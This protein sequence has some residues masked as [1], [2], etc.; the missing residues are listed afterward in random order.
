MNL[1]KSTRIIAKAIRIIT[2]APVIAAILVLVLFGYKEYTPVHAAFALLFLSGL[3]LVSYPISMLFKNCRRRE[4]QRSL[5]I[6]FSV[7]GYIGGMIFCLCTD[8]GKIESVVYL[9][10]LLSGVIT[11]LFSFLF[12]I[13][14]SGHACGVSGPITVMSIFCSPLF[15]L[16]Y[17]LLIPV[18][19]SSLLLKRHT[20]FQ[21]ILGTATPIVCLAISV[22]VFGV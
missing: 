6:A 7:A 21:L 14:A 18:Y 17:A 11:A 5:A 3:P 15:A 9:T 10:Y 12:H 8:S 13:K 19:R 16:G 4:N 22:L 20:P 2:V 1:K